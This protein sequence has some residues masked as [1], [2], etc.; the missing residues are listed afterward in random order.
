MVLIRKVLKKLQEERG[1]TLIELLAVIVI[2]G[3]IAA[4]GIPAIMN[5]RSD[6]E[7][8]T[9]QA[10]AQTMSQTAK[11]LIF[12]GE[13]Y[14]TAKDASSDATQYDMAEVVTKSGITAASGTVDNAAGTYTADGGTYTIN[15]SDG[16]V[17]YAH[18]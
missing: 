12:D 10:N 11:R 18:N 16:T 9:G 2:L 8:S 15:K 14:A 4:I 3:I 13:T 1:V 5:S 7:T 6:A 17:T